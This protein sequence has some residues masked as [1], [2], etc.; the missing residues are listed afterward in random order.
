MSHKQ[1]LLDQVRVHPVIARN[2][3]GIHAAH[4]RGALHDI[5]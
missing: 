4:V 1:R 2:E 5:L 3:Y